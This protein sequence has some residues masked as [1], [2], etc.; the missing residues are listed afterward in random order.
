[1]S[2]SG[3]NDQFTAQQFLPSQNQNLFDQSLSQPQRFS[4][5]DLGNSLC[6]P[7]DNQNFQPGFQ[8]QFSTNQNFNNQQFGFQDNF[9]GSND[10]T[11]NNL[12]SNNFTQD[13]FSLFANNT[14]LSEPFQSNNMFMNNNPQQLPSSSVN[15]ADLGIGDMPSPHHHSPTPPQGFQQPFPQVSS[16]QH[17]PSFNA[18]HSPSFDQ[19]QFSHTPGHSRQTSLQPETAQFPN[20]VPPVNWGEVPQQ[21]KN[22]RRTPSEYSDFSASSAAPSP[23]LGLNHSFDNVD[24]RNSPMMHPQDQTNF[25]DLLNMEQFSISNPPPVHQGTSPFHGRSPAHSP[26]PSPMLNA[27]QGGPGNIN[28]QSPFMLS[29]N[30]NN[31]QLLTHNSAPD[32][33]GH[34]TEQFHMERSNS[35]EMGQAQQMAPPEIN[36]D[37]APPSRQNSFEPPKPA[38]IDQD[39]LLPPQRGMHPFPFS[40]L[41]LLTVL[42]RARPRASSD[43]TF[44]RQKQSASLSPGP[45][46][47]RAGSPHP[48]RSLSPMERSNHRR[49]QSTS[50]LPTNLNPRDYILGLADSDHQPA[51]GAEVIKG[52]SQKHP[53]TFQCTL[54]PK[55]FTRAYNLRSHLRTHTDERPFVCTVC[56]KAFARQH[57]RKRH[58]GLHSGEKK[59]VCKGDLKQG[60]HWGCNRR[61]ARADALGRHFRSEAGRICI[62]PLLDEEAMERQRQWQEQ[63]FPHGMPMQQQMPMHQTGFPMAAN[64]QYALPQRLIEQYPALANITWTD[65]PQGD[66]GMEEDISGRSSFDASGSEYY[67]EEDGYI[68]G[69]GTGYDQG[70]QQ[71]MPT[72]N[73]QAFQPGYASDYGGR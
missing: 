1:M 58:E 68:S 5:A 27:Q 2:N 23:N 61:F 45:G 43:V 6:A 53:A 39:A 49:R 69:P 34:N 56:G 7:S 14:N 3:L 12:G 9:L 35:T 71:Q 46:G 59:F 8:Q 41:Q 62:K 22:H 26:T 17:S 70:Q 13:D 52:R 50:A 55:R 73:Q 29:M 42:G 57:D 30:N 40:M 65:M 67:E 47:L 19:N 36:I 72:M 28:Q 15:P 66:P 63:Q 4:Q 64:G 33:Y 51:A 31:P 10:L 20:A 44:A 24:Q 54:C 60:G 48:A 18:Q 25:Q 11:S 21:F 16:A 32:I 37:L 38:P